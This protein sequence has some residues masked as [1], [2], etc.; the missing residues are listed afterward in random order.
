[1]LHGALLGG[2]IAVAAVLGAIGYGGRTIVRDL[3]IAAVIGIVFGVV[4]GLDLTNRAWSAVGDQVFPTFSAD[5]RP[6]LAGA[7]TLAVVFGILGLLAGGRGGG[8]GGAI[9]GL[10]GGVVIGV[11]LGAFTAI[12][13]GGRVGA[14][15]GV[16]IGLLAW[17]V[18]MGIGLSRRGV[19]VDTLKARFW[20]DETIET[21]KETIEW[22]REQTPLVP[23]S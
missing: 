18:V 7:A 16:A 2:G 19:D 3:V 13:F 5:I 10:L 11:V 14:A 21:T 12:A 15:L 9:V 1:M 17:P 22:V 6:L 8:M 23:K 4:F 20:P